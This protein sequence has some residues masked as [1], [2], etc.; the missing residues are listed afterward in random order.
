MPEEC[1]IEHAGV[2]EE[3]HSGC[4]R[5]TMAQQFVNEK[6]EKVED[7]TVSTETPQ[8]RIDRVANELAMKPSRTEKKFDNENSTPFNK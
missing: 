1:R 3:G 7:E 8:Q 4:R 6:E 2:I 5:K